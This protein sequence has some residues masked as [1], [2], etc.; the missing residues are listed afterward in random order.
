HA[1]SRSRSATRAGQGS[2]QRRQGE[3][4]F[5]KP[6]LQQEVRAGRADRQRQN[7]RD[8]RKKPGQSPRNPQNLKGLVSVLPTCGEVALPHA[9]GK[10][11]RLRRG[12][13][14]AGGAAPEG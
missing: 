8:T 10:Y 2:R 3:E 4:I 6:L 5:R 7:A 9:V 14:S 1:T 13:G 12:W 11:R